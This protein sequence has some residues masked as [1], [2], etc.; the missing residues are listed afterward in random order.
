MWNNKS[1]NIRYVI[2]TCLLVDRD[3]IIRLHREQLPVEAKVIAKERPS[4]K[5]HLIE[6]GENKQKKDS[7]YSSSDINI[8][9]D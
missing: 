4:I 5:Y 8:G 7:S 1:L 2:A 3:L 9:I 6:A